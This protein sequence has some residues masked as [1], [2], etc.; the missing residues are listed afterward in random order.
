MVPTSDVIIYIFIF[1]VLRRLQNIFMQLSICRYIW[2]YSRN[3]GSCEYNQIAKYIYAL[4][5]V[6]LHL[7]VLVKFCDHNTINV[8]TFNALP[9]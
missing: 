3:C 5:H 8:L 6:P 2:K 1:K 9:L 7:E 4:I